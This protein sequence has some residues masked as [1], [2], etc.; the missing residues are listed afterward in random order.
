[1]IR[2]YHV[3]FWSKALFT[4]RG[5]SIVT[6]LGLVGNKDDCR[7]IILQVN[8]FL[9]NRLKLELNLDRCLVNLAW[10]KFTVFLGFQ[11]GYYSQKVAI[12]NKERVS[13][14]FIKNF[15]KREIINLSLLIPIN[16]LLNQLLVWGYVCKLPKS[17]KY[18]GK[19]VGFL[20][21]LSDR[22][23]VD[24][25][26]IMIRNYFNYYLCAN[27]RSKLWLILSILR[28]SCYLTIA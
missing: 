14:I 17:N 24:Y 9:K 23:I 16:I 5:I 3:Q 12:S 19:G 6:L 20:I 13:S 27:K 28:D 2:N 26:S 22:R 1:M 11:I 18:K 8:V 25:F 21:Y 10:E 4:E 15:Q 7:K